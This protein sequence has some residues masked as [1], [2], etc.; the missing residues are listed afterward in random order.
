LV[1]GALSEARNTSSAAF[2]TKEMQSVGQMSTQASHSMHAGSE[3]TVCTSQLRQR[4]ASANATAT[5]KP[6]STS[7]PISLSAAGPTCGTLNRGS[8]VIALS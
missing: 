8:T 2:G 5:S 3:N 1:E 7:M 4:C 6:S